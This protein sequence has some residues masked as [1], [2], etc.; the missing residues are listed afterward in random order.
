[1]KRSSTSF[2][3]R[4]VAKFPR[5]AISLAAGLLAV[6][7]FSLSAH[8]ASYERVEGTFL[9]GYAQEVLK[10]VN[11]ER[12]KEGR[13]SVVMVEE[14]TDVAMMRAAEIAV[15]FSHDRPNGLWCFSAFPEFCWSVGENI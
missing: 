14:L 15:E 5:T 13:P 1:M 6:A 7:G 10:Y 9:Y 3:A 4:L 11:E 8:A 12:S 2:G